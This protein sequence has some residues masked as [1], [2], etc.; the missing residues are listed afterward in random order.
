MELIKQEIARFK[1]KDVTFLIRTQAVQ[2]DTFA[3]KQTDT[4]RIVVKN[5]KAI[6]EADIVAWGKLLVRIFVVGWEGVTQDGKP[7]AYSYDTLESSF[8]AELGDALFEDLA[9]FI[10]A[11]VSIF[12][13]GGVELKNESPAR[14]DGLRGQTHASESKDKTHSNADAVTA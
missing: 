8:P 3:M 10:F 13:K 7:A 5:G 9:N 11:N 6:R 1:H 14:P 2:A 12:K 4:G